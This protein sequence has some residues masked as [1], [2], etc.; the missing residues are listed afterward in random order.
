MRVS[1]TKTS[2]SDTIDK[3]TTPTTFPLQHTSLP[4]HPSSSSA[5]NNITQ[6][7][8]QP[9]SSATI[10][11]TPLDLTSSPPTYRLFS[12]FTSGIPRLHESLFFET[13]GSGPGSGQVFHDT[14]TVLIGMNY[15]TRSEPLPSTNPEFVEKTYPSVADK[16]DYDEADSVSKETENRDERGK[17]KRKGK[18]DSRRS[19]G[20]RK[21]QASK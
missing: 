19:V 13:H 3:S 4:I 18:T 12:L 15:S 20:A 10:T 9:P 21:Y 16:T 2:D 5:T 14:G 11:P 6:T 8:A 7:S 17:E 1:N